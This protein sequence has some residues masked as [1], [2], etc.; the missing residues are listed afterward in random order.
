MPQLQSPLGPLTPFDTRGLL[1]SP[2]LLTLAASVVETTACRGE[3]QICR[4]ES[5]RTTRDETKT[6]NGRR[7][8]KRRLPDTKVRN[9]GQQAPRTRARQEL[10]SLP[11]KQKDSPACPQCVPV[12]STLFSIHI[13]ASRTCMR[14][15]MHICMH[16]IRTFFLCTLCKM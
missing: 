4:Q 13:P 5:G 10:V 9:T 2:S 1:C 12:H 3:G 11:F 8:Q 14:A 7:A 16:F 6:R 15:C